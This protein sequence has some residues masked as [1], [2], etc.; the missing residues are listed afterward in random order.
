MRIDD[1]TGTTWLVESQDPGRPFGNR[2]QRRHY[3]LMVLPRALLMGEEYDHTFTAP[4]G[5]RGERMVDCILALK[6]EGL[7]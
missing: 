5:W 3:G 1:E 7:L 6:Q 4:E 2:L